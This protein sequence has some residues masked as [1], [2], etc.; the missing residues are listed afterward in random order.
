MP[1]TLNTVLGIYSGVRYSGTP[2]AGTTVQMSNL[3]SLSGALNMSDTESLN[4]SITIGRTG[5]ENWI[6]QIGY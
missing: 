6:M 4:P 5:L 3:W 1:Y 2:T